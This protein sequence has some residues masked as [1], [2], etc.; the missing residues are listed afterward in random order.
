[1][2]RELRTMRQA[3]GQPKISPSLDGGNMRFLKFLLPLRGKV[4]IG[5][6]MNEYT[7]PTLISYFHLMH[8]AHQILHPIK[9]EDKYGDSST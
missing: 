7:P 2:L 8:T 6:V 9:G 1:M 5:G 4:R 3:V